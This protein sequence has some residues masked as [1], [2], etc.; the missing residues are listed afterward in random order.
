MQNHGFTF[1]S[2]VLITQGIETFGGILDNKPLKAQAQSKKRFDKALRKLFPP[3]YGFINK[4]DFLYD[5]LR[6]HMVHTLIPSSQIRIV[7][8]DEKNSHQHLSMQDKILIINPAQYQK[9][10]AA[11]ASLLL[12]L[13]EKGEV[14]NKKISSTIPGTDIG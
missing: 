3:L 6:N 8:N 12:Q 5:K 11:A 4:N 10:F 2:V 9:D 14:Y 1:F 13:I 7:S